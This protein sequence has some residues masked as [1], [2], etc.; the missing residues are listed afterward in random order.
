[1][2]T[3]KQRLTGWLAG[4]GGPVQS[5]GQAAVEPTMHSISNEAQV[6]SSSDPRLVE[7]FGG[8]STS[9]GPH[10]SAT[11]AQ[12]VATVYACVT[13]IAGGI[14]TMPIRIYERIWDDKARRYTRREV[15]SASLWWLLN[16]RP[17]AAFSAASHWELCAQAFLLR[18][19]GYSGLIRKNSGDIGEIAPFDWSVVTPKR[20]KNGRLMYAVMDGY[21]A[22]GVDQDDML[23]F[24][25]FG[26][27]GEWAPSVI[28]HAA[29]Q[30]V[31]NALAMDEYSGKFFHNGAHHNMVL[32]T[33]K[34]M[35]PEK[36]NDLQRMYAEKYSGL[37][38]AHAKPMV[39]TEGM[40]AKPVTLSAQDAQLLEGRKYQVIDICRAFGV[41]PHMV[42]E[43][44]A[45]TTWGS[46]LEAI[47]RAFVSYTLNPHLVRMEQELNNK[48][49]R[50][51]R[52][53]L[54]FDRS[55][56]QAGDGKA[57]ADEDKAGLGGPGSGPGW[58][59]VNEV[60]RRRNLPPLD[61]P[62]YDEP[63]W[64]ETKAANSG[65]PAP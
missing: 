40:K 55:A 51:A 20:Q 45:S 54:E 21:N 31:G 12:R 63:F 30:A 13:R 14:S 32:E 49:F 41:P 10:V 57:Q 33:D 65:A 11:S 4:G 25:G 34:K 6:Y 15:D 62:K 52:F 38:N 53:F 8:G 42:G 28:Q 5:S 26:F 39:L 22:R 43:T 24:P 44:S 36:V 35:D 46:G 18:G 16:E 59:S 48:L 60:R 61:G 17:T 9:A 47:G 19:S 50:T 23:H 56:L 37:E 27:D 64:P 1:M 58:V 2:T 7:L 3:L 29:R